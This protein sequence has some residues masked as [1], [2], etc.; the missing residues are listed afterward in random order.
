MKIKALKGKVFIKIDTKQKEKYRLADTDTVIYIEKGYSFNQRED[1]A[2]MGYVIDGCGLPSG[3][4]CLVHH[5]TVESGAELEI[6]GVLTAKEK[7]EGFKVYCIDKNTVFMYED[8][9][10]WLPCE[11]F[12]ITKRVYELYKGTIE[13]VEHE[14]LLIMY[15]VKGYSELYGGERINLEGKYV[16]VLVN[17]DYEIIYH[18]TDNKPHSKIRT[19]S[20]E[21]LA[22]N[23]EAEDKIK[24]GEWAVAT[25]LDEFTL[26]T[27]TQRTI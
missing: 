14:K 22:I 3:A 11:D 20:R 9:G 18:D 6:D 10:E 23:N 4:K 17:A 2:S 26:L 13:G 16:N 19:R 7:E 21:I 27:T 1:R 12:L 25:N 24:K 8:K 5:H 15:V